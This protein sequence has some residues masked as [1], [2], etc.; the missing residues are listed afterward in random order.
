[1]R[2]VPEIR[3][4]LPCRPL[5]LEPRAGLAG[6]GAR[7]DRDARG[8][9]GDGETQGAPAVIQARRMAAPQ[10]ADSLPLPKIAVRASTP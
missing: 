6:A 9:Q 1:M 5:C 8:E 10:A 4:R 7:N 3:G 2:L